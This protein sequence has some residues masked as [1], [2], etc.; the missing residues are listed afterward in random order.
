MV[1]HEG[2]TSNS[3]ELH[4][5]SISAEEFDELLSELERWEA[6]L[7]ELPPVS[8]AALSDEFTIIHK[9][10]GPTGGPS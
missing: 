7:S 5:P 9:P 6:E 2:N 4:K 1:R 8:E 3:T 10:K